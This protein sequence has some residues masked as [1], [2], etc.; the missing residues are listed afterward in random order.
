MSTEP[1]RFRFAARP[2]PLVFAVLFFGGATALFGHLFLTSD[3]PV[4]ILFFF[5]E[6]GAAKVF[7]AGLGLISLG[8]V[9]V[10]VWSA[11]R[12]VLQPRELVVDDEALRL[13]LGV[14][15]RTQHTIRLADIHKVGHTQV[16]NNRFLVVQHTGGTLQFPMNHLP[17]QAAVEAVVARL[18]AG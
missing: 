2:L 16:Y 1:L 15:R 10:G 7:F 9:A 3:R 5:I 12:D 4:R 14:F 6:G 18:R 8:F 17:N 11:I 13:Q